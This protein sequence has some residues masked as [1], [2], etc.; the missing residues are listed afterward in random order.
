[1]P[2]LRAPKE[3]DKCESIHTCIFVSEVFAKIVRQK[4]LVFFPVEAIRRCIWENIWM[5]DE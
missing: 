4:S 2:S 3:I 1:M 5:K